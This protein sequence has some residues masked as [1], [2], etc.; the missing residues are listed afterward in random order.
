MLPW[1]METISK[2]RLLFSQTTLLGKGFCQIRAVAQ[3]LSRTTG[4]V[5]RISECVFRAPAGVL[6]RLENPDDRNFL[7]GLALIAGN[8]RETRPFFQLTDHLFD[9]EKWHEDKFSTTIQTCSLCVGTPESFRHVCFWH[10]LEDLDEV[11]QKSM[12]RLE[13]FDAAGRLSDIWPTKTTSPQKP[14]F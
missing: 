9:I 6:E 3:T 7:I 1:S 12:L 10:D 11:S 14:R 2:H 4:L 5:E 8:E 13:A